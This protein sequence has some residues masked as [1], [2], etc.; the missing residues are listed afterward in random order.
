MFI[1]Y[2]LALKHSGAKNF[3]DYGNFL[4]SECFRDKSFIGYSPISAPKHFK[5]PMLKN[6]SNEALPFH[7]CLQ[8]GKKRR[9]QAFALGST[10]KSDSFKLEPT[11]MANHPWPSTLHK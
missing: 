9:L 7:F 10:Q 8:A 1:A 3:I 4:A 2:I 6:G 5:R 11:A